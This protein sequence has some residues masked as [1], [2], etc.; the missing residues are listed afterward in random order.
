MA[1]SIS[2][3]VMCYSS[4]S[5]CELGRMDGGLRF[6]C[7][8]RRDDCRSDRAVRIEAG[9]CPQCL[10]GPLFARRGDDGFTLQLGGSYLFH[11][12]GFDVIGR[13]G[14]A[15]PTNSDADMWIAHA[16]VL[17][18]IP[19]SSIPGLKPY[20]SLGAAF[21]DYSV[22]EGAAK[23]AWSSRWASE[24]SIHSLIA[25]AATSGWSILMNPRWHWAC[26]SFSR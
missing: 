3:W 8:K 20:A 19:I 9:A 15:L 17:G 11:T 7:H 25:M 21:Y 16:D 10:P 2:S 22:D 12:D 13:G 18:R 26:E 23:M 1:T 14:F 24:P 6:C 5:A 4:C